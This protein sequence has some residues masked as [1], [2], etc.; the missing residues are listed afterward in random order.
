[1]RPGSPAVASYLTHMITLALLYVLLGWLGLHFGELPNGVTPV[2]PP[3]GF[4]I[5]YLVILGLRYWPGIVL[6]SIVLDLATGIPLPTLAVVAATIAVQPVIIAWVLRARTGF[7]P[8][9]ARVKDVVML[10]GIGGVFGSVLGASIGALALAA[11]GFVPWTDYG[12]VWLSWAVG[13]L[14]GIIIVA[15][16]AMT[17]MSGSPRGATPAKTFESVALVSALTVVSVAVYGPWGPFAATTPLPYVVFPFI[18]WLGL[19]SGPHLVSL[20]HVLVA[21]IAVVGTSQGTGPFA[22]GSLVT[23]LMHLTG[24]LVVMTLTGLFLAAVMAERRRSGRALAQS[25]ARLATIFQQAPLGIAIMDMDAR[26]VEVND[27]LLSLLARPKD[28]LLGTR[29]TAFT[30]PRT[31]DED[32]FR[33]LRSQAVPRIQADVRCIRGDGTAVWGRLHAAVI[34]PAP[35]QDPT[36][37]ALVEDITAE[38]RADEAHRVAQ[39]R[40]AKIRRLEETGAWKS[41]VLDIVSHEIKTPL[42]SVAIQAEMLKKEDLGRLTERQEAAVDVLDRETHRM[43]RL[44]HD[45]L[46]VSRIGRGRFQIEP[47]PV[48]LG[49]LVRE[50]IETFRLQ[51]EQKRLSI[52]PHIADDLE[53]GADPDRI[54]QV[55]YN[56]LSNAIKFTPEDGRIEVAADRHD[57]GIEISVTD[58]GPGLRQ[59]Q[60]DRLFRPFSQVLDSQRGAKGMGIGLYISKAIVEQHGGRITC[61]SEGEGR[62]STFSFWLPPRPP[63][64]GRAMKGDQGEAMDRGASTDDPDDRST[65]RR[66]R[67]LDSASRPAPRGPVHTDAVSRG[68]SGHTATPP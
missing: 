54:I 68:G 48:D 57:D 45:V 30:D 3:I 35:H 59:D 21:S 56:L 28:D 29:F 63:S 4:T 15:P 39:E 7:S 31:D 44:V 46:D 5:A 6:G 34:R 50:A 8:R 16:L 12:E 11:S 1:M 41:R 25:R 2:W 13:D 24:F 38:K 60:I 37:V 49:Q 18:L 33:T 42:T 64:D 22:T 19:R 43:D 58:S 62:G 67:G 20:A 55:V 66:S 61:T 10:V 14:F 40:L 23:S 26:L 52:E 65:L 53:V 9:L 27:A 32:L 17:F 47:A 36:V 51:A